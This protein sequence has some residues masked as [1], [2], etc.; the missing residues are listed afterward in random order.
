MEI[1]E[2]DHGKERINTIVSTIYV[3]PPYSY[4]VMLIYFHQTIY[5]RFNQW[6]YY[7]LYVLLMILIF[8]NCKTKFKTHLAR[9]NIMY[10]LANLTD[11]FTFIQWSKD[12][13][14]RLATL[15]LNDSLIRKPSLLHAVSVAKSL[16]VFIQVKGY[17]T[18][19]FYIRWLN[20]CMCLTYSNSVRLY[21][22]WH[23]LKVM[24][25]LTWDEWL[26]QWLLFSRIVS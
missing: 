13:Y 25:S 19:E 1:K 6:L 3:P 9:F 21:Q 16:W 26:G 4:F 24:Y 5:F 17:V 12:A 20:S 23:L 14:I 8:I 22:W 10:C 2:W 11:T 15:K 18:V 7:P